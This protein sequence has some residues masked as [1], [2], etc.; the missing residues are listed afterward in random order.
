MKNIIVSADFL[1]QVILA[2]VGYGLREQALDYLINAEEVMKELRQTSTG[3]VVVNIPG[4]K[5]ENIK[6]FVM[7]GD[8]I[9]AIKA[10]RETTALGLKEAKEIVELPSNWQ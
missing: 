9:G 3:A 6:K 4:S 2:D 5:Y 10:L 1:K 8:K 7:A